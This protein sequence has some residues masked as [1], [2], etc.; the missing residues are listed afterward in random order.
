MGKLEELTQKPIAPLPGLTSAR[1]G[2]ESID[3]GREENGF[4]RQGHPEI[5]GIDM[6]I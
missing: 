2:R 3:W 4:G 6:A 5:V 1:S